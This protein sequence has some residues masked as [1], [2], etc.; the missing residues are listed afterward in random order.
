MGGYPHAQFLGICKMHISIFFIYDF[1]SPFPPFNKGD[2]LSLCVDH[3]L[4]GGCLRRV[5]AE[6][7]RLKGGYITKGWTKS[8][9]VLGLYKKTKD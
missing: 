1:R 6:E 7:G 9:R 5:D 8:S 3:P 2:P 4:K